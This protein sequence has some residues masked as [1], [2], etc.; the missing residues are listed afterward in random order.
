MGI[1]DSLKS[2]KKKTIVIFTLIFTLIFTTSVFAVPTTLNGKT[3]EA[4]EL[5]EELDK[6]DEKLSIVT[7][8]YN[9]A[10]YSLNKTKKEIKNSEATLAKANKDLV[11]YKQA[12]NL[13]AEGIYKHGEINFIEV[14]CS[15]KSFEDFIAQLDLLKRIGQSD[16]ELV[17]A[18]TV[19]KAEIETSKKELEAKKIKQEKLAEQLKTNKL[20]AEKEIKKRNTLYNQIKD[21]IAFLVNEE[22]AGRARLVE[23]TRNRRVVVSRGMPNGRVVDIAMRYLGRPY[24]WGAAGP[25]AFDCSGLVM[26]VYAQM[27]VRLPHSSRAQYSCGA[28]I[29]RNQLQP[30]DLVFFGRPIHHVGI[31]VGGGNFIH[32]PHT[33]DVVSIDSLSSRGNYVGACRP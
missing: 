5:K 6:L 14:L 26:Y 12:L 27:G 1:L 28:R 21:E 31:Y 25:N 24:R 4:K 7:E 11:R 20:E 9:E 2:Q 23:N 17:E 30:G 32:A 15:T 29:S 16:A 13:R 33:G 22:T 3:K 8:R 18:V 10:R 19:K